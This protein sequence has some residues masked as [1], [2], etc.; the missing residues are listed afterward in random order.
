MHVVRNAEKNV[1]GIISGDYCA[2]TTLS[3]DLCPS[4]PRKN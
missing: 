1:T 2:V 4:E 3:V